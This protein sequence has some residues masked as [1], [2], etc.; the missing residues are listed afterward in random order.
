MAQ[1]KERSSADEEPGAPLWMVTFSDCMNLLLT[2]FVL[3]VTFSSFD[4]QVLTNLGYVFRGIFPAIFF[5]PT[6]AQLDESAIASSTQVTPAEPHVDGSEKPTLT[7]GPEDSLR[8]ESPTVDFHTQRAF[9]ADSR[10]IFWGQGTTISSEGRKTL[11]TLALFLKAAP[12]RVIISEHG[13]NSRQSDGLGLERAWAIVE[14]LT[15]SRGLDKKRFS[16][17]MAMPLADAYSKK[18]TALSPSSF[19]KENPEPKA[20]G[21]RTLEIVLLERSRYN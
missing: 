3:L 10:N 6:N 21:A 1:D 9:L 2:F 17:S 5:S 19:S 15:V 12:N 8:S 16:I 4:T 18:E 7:K 11:D 14:Y 13:S 20:Q